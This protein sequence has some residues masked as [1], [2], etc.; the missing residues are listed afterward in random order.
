MHRISWIFSVLIVVRAAAPELKYYS[1]GHWSDG[2][3]AVQATG[4]FTF[5]TRIMDW[6]QEQ[7]PINSL[8]LGM[9]ATWIQRVANDPN[10]SCACGNQCCMDH[11][12]NNSVLA[13]RGTL[14]QPPR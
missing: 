12:K 5:Y 1:W 14:T 2:S 4:G 6:V 3:P 13:P 10:T 8:S 11:S 9:G 7:Y